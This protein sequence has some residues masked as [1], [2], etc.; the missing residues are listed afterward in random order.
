[1]LEYDLIN[2]AKL[3]QQ[4]VLKID[5]LIAITIFFFKCQ[6]KRLFSFF[7]SDTGVRYFRLDL[8]E[9]NR[10][11]WFVQPTI[12]TGLSDQSRYNYARLSSTQHSFGNMKLLDDV[13]ENQLKTYFALS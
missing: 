2:I 1:M 9:K 7:P 3:S 12:I 6:N 13:G 4:N 5:P 8:P 10:K 11:G